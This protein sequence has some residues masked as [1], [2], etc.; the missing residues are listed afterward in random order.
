MILKAKSDFATSA[1]EKKV[2]GSFSSPFIFCPIFSSS[3][4]CMG[5]FSPFVAVAFAH[6]FSKMSW[7]ITMGYIR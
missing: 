4:I 5:R 6:K 2:C 7:I 3:S 1:I